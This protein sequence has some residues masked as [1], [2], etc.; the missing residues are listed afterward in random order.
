MGNARKPPRAVASLGAAPVPVTARLL[1]VGA[2][3]SAAA[4]VALSAGSPAVTAAAS[5][6]PVA[7][8]ATLTADVQQSPPAGTPPPSA[9]ASPGGVSSGTFSSVSDFF[10]AAGTRIQNAAG[11]VSDA[12]GNIMT[13]YGQTQV[14]QARGNWVFWQT[15]PY[16]LPNAVQTMKDDG[17]TGLLGG[18][19]VGL[20]VGGVPG[21]G[22]GL[23]VGAGGGAT[24]G[25]LRGLLYAPVPHDV[26]Q[27]F[28]DQFNSIAYPAGQ[29][30]TV[31]GGTAPS[32]W[33]APA[34]PAPAPPVPAPAPPAPQP[35]GSQDD[36]GIR[37]DLGTET[38]VAGDPGSPADG[39]SDGNTTATATDQQTA[40]LDT[41]S[42]VTDPT[43]PFT[44]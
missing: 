23:E 19:G 15:L 31:T 4:M 24:E 43:D 34:P 25:F 3:G 36:S 33:P 13:S 27:Q 17:E 32:P 29:G 30:A 8:A 21:A 1:T 5:H 10:S 39:A 12:F 44:G 11:A 18:T 26:T 2:L 35:A 41:M 28:F 40:S 7:T 42:P 38:T 37:G 20:M 14:E 16:A 9:A 22:V 6:G